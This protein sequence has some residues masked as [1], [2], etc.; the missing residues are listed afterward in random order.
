MGMTTQASDLQAIHDIIERQFKS[1]SWTAGSAPDMA[2]FGDGFLPDATLYPSARPVSG[3]SVEEFAAR[4]SGLVGKSLVSFHET[5]LGGMIFLFGNVAIA[6]VA[7]EN[8]ENEAEI[9]RNVEMM[10]L[11]KS[12]GHWKI[13]AQAWDRESESL[14]IPDELLTPLR[15]V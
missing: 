6:A 7:C 9:N 14:P 15:I 3:R 12:D 5:V 2:A 13:A 10:L 8:I 11:V 4:M 1:M